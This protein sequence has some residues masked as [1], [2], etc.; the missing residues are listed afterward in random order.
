MAEDVTLIGVFGDKAA[1]LG[2]G[3]GE[4]KT[5][6]VG[7]KLGNLTLISVE[8]ERAT[9]EVDGKRRV[10]ARGQTYSTSGGGGSKGGGAGGRQSVTLAADAGGHFFADGAINGGTMRFVVDTGASAIA[11][12]A[13]DAERLRIDYRKGQR[14]VAKTAN[15]EA[16]TY[17]VR[18][19]TVRIG[20]IELQNVE[21]MV[22]EKGLTV[23][24]LG[25]SFLNR[26]EMQRSGDRMTLTRRF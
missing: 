1:I 14:G 25:M 3:G 17:I 9:I 12:P 13:A 22:L 26:V 2:I 19:D 10:L 21:A 16:A 18:L 6:R 24:L 23:G 11:L 7:Q 15:G 8:R 5:V 20:D 4:P